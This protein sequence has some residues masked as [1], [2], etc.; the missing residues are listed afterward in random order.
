MATR[1]R[2][3]DNHEHG[4]LVRGDYAYY[5]S[6]LGTLFWWLDKVVLAGV[7]KQIIAEATL[8]NYHIGLRCDLPAIATK[9]RKDFFMRLSG[10]G[11]GP[12]ESLIERV[13]A[14]A[15]P[16]GA[17]L[18]IAACSAAVVA[19]G[20]ES[21]KDDVR[22]FMRL[23]YSG[24]N[25]D[26]A[27]FQRKVQTRLGWVTKQLWQQQ[28]TPLFILRS[29]TDLPATCIHLRFAEK[30]RTKGPKTNTK[31]VRE[32]LATGL[33]DTSNAVNI[34]CRGKDLDIP[35]QIL[36]SEDEHS[37]QSQQIAKLVQS[38]KQSIERFSESKQRGSGRIFLAYY[39]EDKRLGGRLFEGL[40]Q[41]RP[42][43]EVI[44]GYNLVKPG[45]KFMNRFLKIAPRCDYSISLFPRKLKRGNVVFEHGY[46]VCRLGECR[47]LAA[48]THDSIQR[49][50]SDTGG[51]IHFRR[52]ATKLSPGIEAKS[53]L[54][55]VLQNI[56]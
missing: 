32:L 4:G 31:P 30:V 29:P 44:D 16:N 53:I 52:P 5:A 33:Y 38:Y 17:K 28:S 23:D 49:I 55:E 27:A 41:A 21:A 12:N 47:A 25:E 9:D 45:R 48:G 10:S 22:Q 40:K 43:Y 15:S 1:H 37:Q 39:G 42:T 36:L 18:H 7:R 20:Y 56:P 26:E 50:L 2:P 24:N 3:S 11:T 8:I 46:F 54:Q 14:L 6:S 19:E 35:T 51:T 34:I 13:L